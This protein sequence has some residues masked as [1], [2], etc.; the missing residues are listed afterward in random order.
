ML[1]ELIAWAG[2]TWY[3][4]YAVL[5][6][7]GAFALGAYEAVTWAC[8]SP[9]DWGTWA[10]AVGTVATLVGTIHI[11]TTESRRRRRSEKL[12]AV[13]QAQS[14]VARI[15]TMQA[16]A[17]AVANLLAR[18]A[19]GELGPEIIPRATRHLLSVRS[20]TVEELARLEP[21]SPEV[22]L[23]LAQAAE[24]LTVL[25]QLLGP[26]LNSAYLDAPAD[27]LPYVLELLDG[28]QHYLRTGHASLLESLA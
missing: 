19:S 26:E 4:R 24:I 8:L 5:A 13:T 27:E 28:L 11:A 20:W 15:L 21:L 18:V 16:T 10:G 14:F 7:S 3:N 12:L 1:W 17:R 2:S 23:T 25:Q 9:S 22:V 6:L